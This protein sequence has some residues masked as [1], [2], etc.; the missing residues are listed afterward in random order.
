MSKKV[1]P[2]KDSDLGKKEQVT[3]MFDTISTN[4]DGLN[5]VISFGIDIKWRK[6][7]VA[8]LKKK[9]PT[10]ILDIA[11]GTGDLAINL[12]ETGASKIV[13]LDISPGMLAVG[14]KKVTQKQLD[15]TIE[16]IVGDSENLPFDEN[17]FDAVTVAFGVRNFENLELGLSEIY[18]VLKKGGTLAILETSVP[19]KTP[20]KQGYKFYTKQIMPKIGKLFSKDN[21][22]YEY[23]SESAAVFPYGKKFNNILQK[24]GFIDIEDKPQTLGV[25]SI[26]VAT[27]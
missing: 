22:A 19:T 7:V 4:Y 26:Y 14:K 27:K 24:I 3:Q 17:T 21:S 18:R 16:M 20:F 12:I 15:K 8:I 2:Y 6:R 13:G 23:L 11:T 25:A 5:R 10:S 9:N 1:T